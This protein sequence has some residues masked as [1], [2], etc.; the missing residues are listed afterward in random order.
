[1][2]SQQSFPQ[3][4]QQQQQQHQQQV[5]HYQYQPT[6]HNTMTTTQ[7]HSYNQDFRCPSAQPSV[8]YSQTAPYGKT[9]PTPY[10]R[11][12]MS[13]QPTVAGYY[14]QPTVQSGRVKVWRRTPLSV[15]SAAII[16]VLSFIALV[17]S[18][19]TPN[20]R[21]F[22]AYEQSVPNERFEGLWLYCVWRSDVGDPLPPHYMRTCYTIIN[23]DVV[24][25]FDR[26]YWEIKRGIDI[27]KKKLLTYRGL[28]AMGSRILFIWFTFFTYWNSLIMYVCLLS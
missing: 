22:R 27:D 4:Q 15:I 6:H 25:I 23:Y 19:S 7:G 20:W 8:A 10:E 28:Y 11:Q 14:R 18:F 26:K 12:T 16:S 13:A 21:R 3:Y 24:E 9:W 17:I 5:Y 1:M 2:Y